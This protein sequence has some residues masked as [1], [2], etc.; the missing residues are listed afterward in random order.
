LIYQAPS[1]A[2]FRGASQR[3]ST[4]TINWGTTGANIWHI[5]VRDN[6][7][8]TSTVPF[9]QFPL[10]RQ[11]FNW[12]DNQSGTLHLTS[13]NIMDVESSSNHYN[14]AVFS[15]CFP[16]GRDGTVDID[17]NN[18]ISLDISNDPGLLYLNAS[19]NLLNQ[20]SVD[21]LLQT[22]DSY[23]TNG[24]HLDLTGNAAP[25]IIGISHANNL[26]ARKWKVQVAS[27]N[28]Q[29]IANFT[30]SVTIGTIPLVVQFNDTSINNP[31]TWTWDFGDGTYSNEEFPKHIYNFP[32]N[33]TVTLGARNVNGSDF[34]IVVIT[35]LEQPVLPLANFSSNVTEGCV[36]LDV[37]FTDLSENATEWSWDFGDGANSTEQNPT[38]T[39]LV[40]GNSNVNLTVSNVNG[41]ASKTATI[42]ILQAA[43]SG[44]D[45]SSGGG[46]SSSGSS[47]GGGGGSPEPQSNVEAKELSQ[48]FVTVGK[49]VKFD[50][51]QKATPVVYL[52]F[53]S[54]KTSGK[55]TTIVE[56]LKGK[57]TLVSELPSEE[58]YKSLNIW[59]GNGGFATEKNIENAVVNFRVEKSWVQDKNIDQSSITLNRYSDKTWNQLTTSLSGEDDNCLYFTAQTPGFS[60]FAIT[61]KIAA[62]LA[63]IQ[64]AAGD[65][66]QNTKVRETQ[67]VPNNGSIAT[68]IEQSPEQ[69]QSNNTFGKESAKMPSFDTGFG[70]VCLLCVFL[71]TRRKKE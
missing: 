40:T 23:N 26:T 1:L 53:D 58:V 64:P 70:I 50:F 31:K 17:N 2:D 59:V 9:S 3:S 36:P 66:T 15:D 8:I 65:K 4:Y 47:G 5:C 19:L 24:G 57:S 10:L 29:P 6:P 54:K 20:T 13:T 51:P 71:Y 68:N 67:N 11:F 39:Y 37:Q 30:S 18:L 63:G 60:P 46:S 16:A 7:Q 12:N 33:Y 34:K 56:M 52:S 45:G 61:G 49:L 21:G 38:H 62:S 14:Y 42:N 48:A 44:S 69:T 55:T 35:V 28:N 41:T 27:K 43:D 25:S 32:G 22:L